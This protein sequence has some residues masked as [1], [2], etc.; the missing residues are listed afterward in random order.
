MNDNYINDESAKV[1]G[2]A[3]M[4]NTTLLKIDLMANYIGDDGV[5]YITEAIIKNKNS[6][7]KDLY[8]SDNDFGKRY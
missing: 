4:I 7:L 8:L 3:L 1:I 6:V 2:D 5:N